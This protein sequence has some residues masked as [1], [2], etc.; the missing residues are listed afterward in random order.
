MPLVAGDNLWRCD[1]AGA[2][3]Q[4][5]RAAAAPD[6]AGV[7]RQRRRHRRSL[8]GLVLRRTQFRARRRY[9]KNIEIFAAFFDL[10]AACIVCSNQFSF[11]VL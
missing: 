3:L 2:L 8:P 1:G 7:R 5:D 11:F 6:P 4:C 9:E 10:Q